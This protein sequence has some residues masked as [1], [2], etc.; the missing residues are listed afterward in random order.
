M[1]H[2][3]NITLSGVKLISLLCTFQESEEAAPGE[4]R[5]FLGVR[6]QRVTHL[7]VFLGLGFSAA[8]ASVLRFMVARWL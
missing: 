5:R 4:K 7:A 6:E 3:A 1:S 2:S 8:A